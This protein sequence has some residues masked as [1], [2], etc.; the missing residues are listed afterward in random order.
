MGV[1]YWV[2]KPQTALDTARAVIK[3]LDKGH[4]Y[5]VKISTIGMTA[6][7]KETDSN[8]WFLKRA[9]IAEQ[10]RTAYLA[11]KQTVVFQYEVWAHKAPI[12]NAAHNAAG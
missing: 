8:D 2:L 11:D 5:S 7:K 4:W 10:C 3:A 9:E 1:E 12:H 6:Y